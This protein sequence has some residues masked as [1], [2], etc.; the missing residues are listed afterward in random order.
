MEN[1]KSIDALNKLIEINNDRVEGYETAAKEADSA[2]LKSLFASLQTTSQ[3]NLTELRSEVT[4]LGGKPEEGTRVTG[5]FF[6]AW[7]DVKAAFTGNDRK[8]I[9][10]SCEF[11]EDKALETYENV[12]EENRGDLAPEQLALIAKQQASLTTDHDR[13]KALRDA[14]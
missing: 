8:T 11:G 2:D 6:R 10:N 13:V 9:L 4:R 7:M 5:K 3:N 1:Q 14:A 12:L